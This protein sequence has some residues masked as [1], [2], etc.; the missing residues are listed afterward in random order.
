MAGVV[1]LP[2]QDEQYARWM[3]AFRLAC[4]GKTMADSVSFDA[5]MK[6]IMSLLSMQ[7]R[8]MS[9]PSHA[10]TPQSPLNVQPEDYVASRFLKKLKT[11]QVLF[12]ETSPQGFSL[13]VYHWCFKKL[14]H[15]ASP[16]LLS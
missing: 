5:E 1:I 13:V 4:K 2:M 10:L 14:P 3:A 12:A 9:S 8:P 6:S 15:N 16:F 7:K 11:K